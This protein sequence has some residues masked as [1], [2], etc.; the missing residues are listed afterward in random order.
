[1]L[2]RSAGG[3]G[4]ARV[5]FCWRRRS[6]SRSQAVLVGHLLAG[7]LLDVEALARVAPPHR[8]AARPAGVRLAQI[9]VPARSRPAQQPADDGAKSAGR[10]QVEVRQKAARPACP[11]APE[12]AQT[13]AARTTFSARMGSGPGGGHVARGFVD[14]AAVQDVGGEDVAT[15]VAPA[16]DVDLAT[17]SRSG[18]P[19]RPE[20]L[21]MSVGARAVSVP[22]TT[23]NCPCPQRATSNAPGAGRPQE[24][25]RRAARREH[26]LSVDDLPHLADHPAQGADPGVTPRRELSG[27]G[28][29]DVDGSGDRC[30]CGPLPDGAGLARGHDDRRRGLLGR[31]RPRS[32]ACETDAPA[33]AAAP[34]A[35]VQAATRAMP[36]H[37]TPLGIP[38]TIA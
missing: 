22:G 36:F 34:T 15:T 28:A 14:Q 2:G 29:L 7:V 1:M 25:E 6:R 27:E 31:A 9:C 5:H 19:D 21:R 35:T 10:G 16:G 8:G 38:R 4:G 26:R 3:A 37:A 24:Q 30:R 17:A 13:D 32:P 23:G 18:A 12:Q 11:T 33:T 20:W